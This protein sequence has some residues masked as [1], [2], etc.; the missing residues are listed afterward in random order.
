MKKL[1]SMSEDI[2]LI[3]KA[4]KGDQNALST[5]YHK[6]KTIG[7]KHA[8]IYFANRNYD[9]YIADEY[10]GEID[11]V[12]INAFHKFN[13]K[14]SSF[15]AYFIAILENNL[16]RYI[17]R[18]LQSNDALKH[19]VPLDVSVDNMPLYDLIEDRTIS[20]DNTI[21]ELLDARMRLSSFE[22][23]IK[24]R[25]KNNARA[26]IILKAQGYSFREIASLL[27]ISESSVTRFYNDFKKSINAK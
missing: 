11:L 5:L 14:S 22:N 25:N 21:S 7:E 1:N 4:D 26:V 23:S 16:S 18:V 24:N 20:V 15:R 10:I 13:R 12:F 8:R 3:K 17:G 2:I 6:Y 19:Y 27:S 9:K